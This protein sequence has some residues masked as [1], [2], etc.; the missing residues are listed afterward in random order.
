MKQLTAL[1]TA[2]VLLFSLSTAAWAEAEKAAQATEPVPVVQASD[3][4]SDSVPSAAESVQDVQTESSSNSVPFVAGESVQTASSG[5]PS[6]SVPSAA[7]APQASPDTPEG[8]TI[9]PEGSTVAENN[10]TVDTNQGTVEIN[11]GTVTV[12]AETGTV[13]TNNNTV[14]V[15]SG[16]VKT[17][18]GDVRLSTGTIEN[19]NSF[20]QN[21]GTVIVNNGEVSDLTEGELPEVVFNLGQVQYCETPDEVK[22]NAGEEYRSSFNIEKDDFD[23]TTWYGVVYANEDGEGFLLP[24][25]LSEQILEKPAEA[26]SILAGLVSSGDLVFTAAEYDS[27][28]PGKNGILTLLS[29]ADLSFEK[30]GYTLS[31]WL[32]A[33]HNNTAYALGETVTVTAP[34]WLIPNWVLIPVPSSGVVPE[35]SGA[36]TAAQTG[37]NGSFYLLVPAASLQSESWDLSSVTVTSPDPRVTQDSSLPAAALR[38]SA[39][40]AD[41]LRIWPLKVEFDGEILPYGSFSL[42]FHRDGTVTLLFSRTFL[43]TQPEGEHEVTLFLQDT[44]IDVTILLTEPSPE[45][46]SLRARKAQLS[47]AFTNMPQSSAGSQKGKSG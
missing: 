42:S 18:D 38:L 7:G 25:A 28:D 26:K 30:S 11:N 21:S 5:S 16:T 33:R 3:S 37:E 31:G 9:I 13:I 10:G 39:D 22:Y 17:N 12:N 32:D 19:N 29:E 41:V 40:L 43:N 36:A 45:E 44:E 15:N 35:S 2:A 8:E 27:G 20:A 34:L 6:D 46:T 23:R 1:F 24:Q 4:S 47:G 14:T